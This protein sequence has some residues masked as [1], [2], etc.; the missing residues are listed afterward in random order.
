MS[1]SAI[2]FIASIKLP[3]GVINIKKK[4]NISI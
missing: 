2:P 4:N 1:V 3:F